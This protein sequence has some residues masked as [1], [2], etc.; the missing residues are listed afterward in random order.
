MHHINNL[1]F[2]D[3]DMEVFISIEMKYIKMKLEEEF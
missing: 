1:T 3:N 2:W